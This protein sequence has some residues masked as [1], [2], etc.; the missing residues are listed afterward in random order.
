MGVLQRIRAAVGAGMSAW[1][2]TTPTIPEATVWDDNENRLARYALYELYY[3]NTPYDQVLRSNTGNQPTAKKLY[4][5]IRPIYNPVHRLVQ[6]YQSEV[7]GGALD[8]EHLTTGAMRIVGADDTLKD[9][10]R[11][12]LKWSNW[13]TEKGWFVH[14]GALYG[15]AFLKVI[16]DR[17]RRKVRLEVLAP[18]KVK[19]ME[20]DAVGNIV[21]I[22]I[23]YPI[24]GEDGKEQTYRE[25]I[26]KEHFATFLDNDPYSVFGENGESKWANVYGFVPVV[27][28]AFSNT[29]S[30]FGAN[31]FHSQLPKIN[32][33]DDQGSV[34]ND[35][36]RKVVNPIWAYIGIAP[37]TKDSENNDIQV[38]IGRDGVP[39]IYTTNEKARI[40]PII[41][42]INIAD[43]SANVQQL[44][45]EVE[46]DLPELA[47]YHMRDR[48][49]SGVA[50]RNANR[51]AIRRLEHAHATFAGAYVRAQQMAI[52]MGGMAKYEGFNA[53]SIHSYDRGELEFHVATPELFKDE[54]TVEQRVANLIKTGAPPKA[55][56]KE[57]G[58]GDE[59]IEEW[60]VEYA[61][62]EDV[63]E[64]RL[65]GEYNRLA[66]NNGN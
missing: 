61:S 50:I 22:V 14:N 41:S 6:T 20:V 34:L 3:N 66:L 2:G 5:D 45:R 46:R 32:E 38:T 49:M 8:M 63:I 16:D 47:L 1:R 58:Y 21:E 10:I 39:A 30:L 42:N 19:S 62:R 35:N 15:D 4:K 55:V 44:I 51:D 12:T 54:L 9:A 53:Y 40:E 56:W 11:Q 65:A 60:E 7:M 17:V 52:T 29:G 33:I 57:L 23:E 27:H 28:C 18:Q 24:K 64:G 48:Q 26:T 43:A 31:A 59:L 13:Q 25:E 37:P 36:V